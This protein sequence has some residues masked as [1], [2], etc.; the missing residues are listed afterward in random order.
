MPDMLGRG[1]ALGVE[2]ALG[3]ILGSL[4][5]GPAGVPPEESVESIAV[6]ESL[7]RVLL[8]DIVSPEDLPGFA[9]STVDG[10]AVVA[11]DTFGAGETSP[12]YISVV[13]EIPMGQ[14][15]AFGLRRG[16]AA[17]I[18]TGGMLPD[19]ADAVLMLEHAQLQGGGMIEAQRALAP[20]ENVIQRAEDVRAGEL[21]LEKGRLLRPQDM[22]VLAGIGMAGVSVYRRPLVSIISTG[23]E[24]VPPG[25]PL[26]PGLVR[27]MNSYNLAGLVLAEGCVPLR[28]GILKDDYGPM[29]D[30]VASAAD[31]SDCVLISG[32]SSVGT[33]D[34]T[35]RIIADLGRVL[36]HSVSLKP[37]KPLM[38]GVIGGKPVF[39]L[40]GHPRA[41]SVCFEIFIRPVLARLKGAREEP[42]SRFK[43]T[44]RARLSKGVHSA[45]GRQEIVSVRLEEKGG[46]LVAIP[47]LGKSGLITT[48]VR[49]HG[50][51][52][53]P[54]DKPG[55]ESGETVE[56]RLL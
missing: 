3:L 7:G 12:S 13:N 39:G 24:V 43:N 44:V 20:G 1:E 42:L 35:E 51:F 4:S 49:A 16:E 40:P 18:S 10:F 27:D 2:E 28:R 19:G 41:V 31:G 26:R 36:F 25:D 55:V 14:E 52:T 47:L 53:I 15:P 50:T 6:E 17:R 30:A 32:G 23:D 5:A 48:L 29:R 8:R 37:G 9:R 45:S 11:A 46:E 22:A 33:R 38:A 21:L 54:R 34:L 56:V